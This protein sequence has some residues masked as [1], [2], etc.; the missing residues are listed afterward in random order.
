MPTLKT[1]T[2]PLH[3]TRVCFLIFALVLGILSA[4]ADAPHR[5]LAD[6]QRAFQAERWEEARQLYA[7]LAKAA[8][9]FIPAHLGAGDAAVKLKDY[10]R[11][12]AAFQRALQL[13]SVLPQAERLTLEANLQA[14]LAAAYHRYK[15][16]EK[17][18]EWFQKAIKSAGES[19]PVA[20]YI[21]LGQIETER[22]NLEQARRYYIVAVQLEPSAT[23]AYN[24]LGHVLLKLNRFDEADAVFREALTQN[25]TLASAAFGRGEV[26]AKR[27]QFAVARDFYQRAIRHAPSTPGFH[28]ALADVLSQLGDNSGAETARAR[29]RRTLAEGYL[30]QAHRLL[31]GQ[32]ARSALELLHKAVKADATFMPALKDYAYVQMQLGELEAAKQTYHRVL[33]RETTSRQALLH[34]G[35][36]AARQD[37]RAAAE[38]HFL[39]LIRH[40]PDFMDTYAQLARLR[41]ASDDLEGAEDAWTVGIRHEPKWAPGY[42]RRGQI[43]QKRR[44]TAGAE[45]DFRKAIHLA[46]DA[47]YPKHALA[48]L[49]AEEGK[50]LDEALRLAKAAV[51]RDESPAHRATLARVYYLLNRIAD[52]RREIEIAAV[53]APENRYVLKIRSEILQTDEK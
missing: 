17:A 45:S 6:A 15:K 37:N 11:A 10:P 51:T 53:Q 7:S 24:N 1:R 31:E 38:S 35:M 18:D 23:A 27:G 32:Q 43:R 48:L 20:W 14:K 40:E 46:P 30:R 12:I 26:A 9:E 8:P 29:Y 21:A 3:L 33:A 39:A 5:Q 22:G 50:N 19:A 42:W 47:P 34:L 49:F 44:D 4:S 52:A 36:I 28:K 16:L 13:L 41:E 25:D 2:S